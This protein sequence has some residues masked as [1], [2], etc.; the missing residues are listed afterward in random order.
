MYLLMLNISAMLSTTLRWKVALVNLLMYIELVCT[1]SC[2]VISLF[3]FSFALGLLRCLCET[4][5]M[6]KCTNLALMMRYLRTRDAMSY[7]L[8][9]A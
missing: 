4:L 7:C 9:P 1:A 3:I 6:C 8:T 2:S 5:H